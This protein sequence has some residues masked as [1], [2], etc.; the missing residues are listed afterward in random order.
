MTVCIGCARELSVLQQQEGTCRLMMTGR[1][2][3]AARA[4]GP[5]CWR[6]ASEFV[7]RQ[8]SAGT[9][10]QASPVR[11]STLTAVGHIG[12]GL[13]RLPGNPLRASTP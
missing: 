12:P 6:C 7:R 3:S 8:D 10:S 9:R 11:V 13:Q 5:M 4:C 2:M 1:S